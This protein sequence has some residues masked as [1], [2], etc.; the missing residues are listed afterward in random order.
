MKK[1]LTVLA[2]VVIALSLFVTTGN[3]VKAAEPANDSTVTE[4]NDCACHDVT[5]IVGAEKIKIV[6]D[7]FVSN[8]FKKVVKD[9]LK[10]A[11]VLN[12]TADIEVV[13]FNQTGQI[14]I[15]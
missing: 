5:M 4:P 3:T 8:E 1:L 15:G 6:F 7:L 14:M 2:G 9:R 13:K 11:F 10:E 12:L